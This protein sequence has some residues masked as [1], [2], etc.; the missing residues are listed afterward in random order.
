MHIWISGCQAFKMNM[1]S[2]ENQAIKRTL[3]PWQLNA[4]AC[5]KV[6]K[7]DLDLVNVKCDGNC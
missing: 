4:K 7:I 3:T 2:N 6:E 5:T 1:I